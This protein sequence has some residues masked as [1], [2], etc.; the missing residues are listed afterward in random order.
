MGTKPVLSF[1]PELEFQTRLL[2]PPTKLLPPYYGFPENSQQRSGHVTVLSKHLRHDG[3][4]SEYEV[5]APRKHLTS[6][7]HPIVFI[8]MLTGIWGV[9][10]G[11]G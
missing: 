5:K 7:C 3:E 4:T 10:R 6:N 1:R 2:T 9:S 8:I 11:T